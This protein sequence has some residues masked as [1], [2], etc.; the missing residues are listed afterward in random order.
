MTAIR[1]RFNDLPKLPGRVENGALRALGEV[2]KLATDRARENAPERTGR[3]R[4]SIK[5]GVELDARRRPVLTIRVEAPYAIP[6]EFGTSR[7]AGRF[8]MTRALRE[9]EPQYRQMIASIL[10]NALEGK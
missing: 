10:A 8:F 2:G 5:Y 6:V 9:T 7:R 4:R 3:L 1:Y